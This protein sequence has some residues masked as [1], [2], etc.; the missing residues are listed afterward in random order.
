M[1]IKHRTARGRR[2]RTGYSRTDKG[3]E[4]AMKTQWQQNM[5]RTPWRVLQ[6]TF[7]VVLSIVIPSQ[8]LEGPLETLPGTSFFTW[9]GNQGLGPSEDGNMARSNADGWWV[10]GND[11][12]HLP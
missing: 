10:T 11:G 8:A 12:V 1:A 7:I 9:D 3:Q 6:A 2:T 5:S 4:L